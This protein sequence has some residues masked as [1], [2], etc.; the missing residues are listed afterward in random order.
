MDLQHL[1]AGI[2]ILFGVV[3]CRLTPNT[4][5]WDSKNQQAALFVV[6]TDYQTGQLARLNLEDRSAQLQFANIHSDAVIRI[7]DNLAHIFIINRLGA[8]NIQKIDP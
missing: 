7:F 6:T 2:V 8:D 1:V 5:Q 3:G 4:L